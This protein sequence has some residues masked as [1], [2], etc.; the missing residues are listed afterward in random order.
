MSSGSAPSPGRRAR[1]MLGQIRGGKGRYLASGS[2]VEP[3][4]SRQRSASRILFLEQSV[5]R[6]WPAPRPECCLAG[7]PLTSLPSARKGQ[8][9]DT[10]LPPHA[11]CKARSSEPGLPQNIF[12]RQF[13][14]T[15][16]CSPLNILL[17]SFSSNTGLCALEV[18]TWCT[19]WLKPQAGPPLSFALPA[20]SRV[21]ALN[22]DTPTLRRPKSA[23]LT[24]CSLL[25][26]PSLGTGRN[27]ERHGP[28]WGLTCGYPRAGSPTCPVWAG[29]Q[30]LTGFR[31]RC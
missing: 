22:P 2:R 18:E 21:C 10:T 9:C 11:L 14:L 4:G 26:P 25:L 5:Y 24:R 1:A 28:G 19:G 16:E 3:I 23:S 12:S 31:P 7:G 29:G 20:P 27:E 15:A 8:P 6:W 30:I 13:L 17:S